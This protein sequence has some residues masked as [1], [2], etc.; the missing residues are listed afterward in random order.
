MDYAS[1][2]A[3]LVAILLI[4]SIH[5]VVV[6]AKIPSKSVINR[7]DCSNKNV[8]LHLMEVHKGDFERNHNFSDSDYASMTGEANC[9]RDI[10]KSNLFRINDAEVK[11][12]NFFLIWFKMFPV[13]FILSAYVYMAMR[14]PSSIAVYI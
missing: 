13:I 6:D 5:N 11:L 9:G 1:K 14:L 3:V 12:T 8:V 7:R 10:W 4:I 2:W